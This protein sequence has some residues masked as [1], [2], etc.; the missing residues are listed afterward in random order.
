MLTSLLVLILAFVP[1]A[2]L[3]LC[4]APGRERWVVWACVPVLGLGLTSLAMQWLPVFGLPDSALWVLAAELA[5]AG[6]AVTATQWA[7]RRRPQRRRPQTGGVRPRRADVVGL[8]VPVV[9][10]VTLGELIVGRLATPPGVDA[11]N[12]AFMTRRMVQGGSTAI[13]SACTTGST[14]PAAACRFYPLSANAQWAQAA[15]LSGGH[16]S[17]AMMAWSV[18]IGPLALVAAVYAAV[19]VLGAGPP[20]AGC[21]AAIPAVLSPLWTSMISGRLTEGAAP[22]LSVAVALLIAVALRGKYPVRFGILAGLGVAAVLTTHTYDVLFVGTLAPAFAVT[23]SGR[24]RARSTLAALGALALSSA[25]AIAPLARAL[26]GAQGERMTAD[27]AFVGQLGRAVDFWILSPQRYVLLGYPSPGGGHL[28]AGA[29]AIRIGLALTLPCL[30]ASPLCFV[31]ARLR[32]ARPWF[33]SWVG[34]AI[35]EVW[36][37]TS[38]SAAARD[39]ANLW[40]GVPDRVRTMLLPL[41]GVLAVAGAGAIGLCLQRLFARVTRRDAPSRVVF[42]VA[43]PIVLVAALVVLALPPS[44]RAPLHRD[45]AVRTPVGPSYPRVFAWLSRHTASADVIAYDQNLEFITWAYADY[46]IDTL[47]GIGALAPR[48][49]PD[50]AQRWRAWSWLVDNPGAAPAG[51][52][53]RTYRVAYVVVGQ[54]RIPVLKADYSRALLA[55]SPNVRLVHEDGGLQVYQVTPAGAACP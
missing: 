18:L 16:I 41:Y 49:R 4:V 6:G 7:Q 39:L 3:G 15:T 43:V 28:P 51:C 34:W 32:W 33:V 19:R 53:V 37:S 10:T 47:L 9:I 26:L 31:F 48:A 2:L 17:T 55:A 30:L 29:L 54:A 11:M 22:G 23:L 21:A 36:T 50:Y 27:P 20:V 13:S 44:S 5:L 14:M 46:G 1:G 52:A 8:S 35:L 24:W 38:D 40:Y 42:G 25:V 45:L 12:L